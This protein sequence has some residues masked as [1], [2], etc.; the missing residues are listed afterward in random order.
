MFTILELQTNNGQT[1]IPTPIKTAETKNEAMSIYHGILFSA[2]VSEVHCH[3][4]M[5]I[6]E[7]GKTLARETYIHGAEHT[8]E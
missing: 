1:V 3:T 2:A 6:D 4:A 8:S 7:E 5:V